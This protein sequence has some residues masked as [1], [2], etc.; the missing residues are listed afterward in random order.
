MV[1]PLYSV[2][3]SLGPTTMRAAISLGAHPFTAFLRVYV[4][5]TMPGVF[6]GTL[7]VFISAI[8]YYITPALIGGADDQ[9]LSYFIAFYTNETTNWG[10]AGALG[11]VLLT[12]TAVLYLIYSR[13]AG[14]AGPRWA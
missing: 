6:A 8:G 14:G 12:M 13:L 4:P 7:L 3:K 11:V 9:M 2:M 10:L 5:Q 1:L